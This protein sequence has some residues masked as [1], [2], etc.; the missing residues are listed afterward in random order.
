MPHYTGLAEARPL[1][2]A[3]KGADGEAA[4]RRRGW[5]S[6]MDLGVLANLSNPSSSIEHF[7]KP[8]VSDTHT[9]APK[10]EPN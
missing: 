7:G 10:P 3:H 4:A 8:R 6:Q 2:R 9:A 1:G 5:Q